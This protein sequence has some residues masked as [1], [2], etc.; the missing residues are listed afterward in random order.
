[1][2]FQGD[3]NAEFVLPARQ[4]THDDNWSERCVFLHLACL[5][6]QRGQQ[7]NMMSYSSLVLPRHHPHTS[8]RHKFLLFVTFLM[9]PTAFI[10]TI[11]IDTL[12]LKPS[13]RNPTDDPAEAD[14][15]LPMDSEVLLNLMDIGH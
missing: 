2:E 8:P 10:T 11:T 13:Q 15:S 5:Q 12:L 6:Q 4:S 14:P 7:H 9:F 1:M 3:P